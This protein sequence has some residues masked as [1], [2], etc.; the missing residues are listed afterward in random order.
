MS[1]TVDPAITTALHLDSSTAK[2]HPHGHS[3]FS[4]TFKL[5]GTT[6][7]PP[8]LLATFFIKT[9]TGPAAET[10]FR[11]E[12]HSLLSL[13]PFHLAPHPHFHGPLS[14]DPQTFFLATSF[15]DLSP[16][17]PG[18]GVSLARK[19]ANLHTTPAPLPP[20]GDTTPMFGFP[21]P[22]CCGATVQDNTFRASWAEFFAQQRLLAALRAG[23]RENGADRELEGTVGEVVRVVVPRLLSEEYLAGVRPVV[24]HG[25]LWGGNCGRTRGGEGEEVVFDPAGYEVGMM[26]MFGGFGR[27]FWDEYERLV[28]RAEP[29]EDWKGR[30][31]LYELYHHLNHWVLFGGGYRG[32]AMRIMKELIAEYGGGSDV[33][34]DRA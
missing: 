19:L 2:M 23:V 6:T 1:P 12:F 16:S 27:E 25:D 28:R 5:T 31:K 20:G 17:A 26:R 33:Q 15:L 7:T 29:M 21:V 24:V 11:G 18:P 34:G 13:S 4:S 14:R 8:G 32:G 3:T 9:G 10:M 22:T 30:V